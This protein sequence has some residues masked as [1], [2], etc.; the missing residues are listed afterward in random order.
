M[1]TC[2]ACARPA[3]RLLATR[4]AAV[5]HDTASGG[6]GGPGEGCPTQ[7]G[8][9]GRLA[10]DLVFD[11]DGGEA[12]PQTPRLTGIVQQASEI[13]TC[14]AT[15][16][17]LQ[18][19]RRPVVTA[20]VAIMLHNCCVVIPSSMPCNSFELCW[21]IRPFRGGRAHLSSESVPFHKTHWFE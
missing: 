10:D 11:F 5:E 9:S 13:L 15:M 7:A 12:A 6:G 4:R 3:S 16:P 14:Q 1:I 17:S 18:S 20:S 21:C 2:I 19:T 8:G